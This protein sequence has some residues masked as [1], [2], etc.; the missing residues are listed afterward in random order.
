MDVGIVWAGLIV[1][2]SAGLVGYTWM[3]GKLAMKIVEMED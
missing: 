1:V 3:L 2:G